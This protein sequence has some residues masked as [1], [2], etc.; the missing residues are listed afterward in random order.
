MIKQVTHISKDI[1]IFFS[2]RLP[3]VDLLA[4]EYYP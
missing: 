3:K 1:N 2:K 4:S